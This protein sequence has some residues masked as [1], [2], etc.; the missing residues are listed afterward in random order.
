[1]VSWRNKPRAYGLMAVLCHWITAVAVFGL[2]ALGLWMVELNYYSPWYQKAPELHRSVGI[3]LAALVVWRLIW[4]SFNEQPQSLPNHRP[5]EKHIAKA[6]HLLLYLLLFVM[7][8][9]G[10]LITTGEGDPLYVFGWI[11]VPA[12]ISGGEIGVRNLQDLAG[13]IHEIAAYT[14]VA[15]ATLHALAALKHHFVDKD[16]TLVRMFGKAGQSRN[17][18]ILQQDNKPI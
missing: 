18:A 7:F 15:L 2:F 14:L 3:L 13:D 16:P 5:W 9:S 11:A 8:I 12:V 6:M 4:R 1:M 10:Y 17:E